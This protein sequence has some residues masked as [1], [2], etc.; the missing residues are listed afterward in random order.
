MA[1]PRHL[2]AVRLALAAFVVLWLLGPAVLRSLFPV[3]FVFLL[4]VGLELHFFLGA[5]RASHHLPDR[6][7]QE[8]DRERYGFGGGDGDDLL[9]VRDGDEDLWIRRPEEDDD[10]EELLAAARERPAGAPV[11][12]PPPRR[13]RSRLRGLLVAVMAVAAFGVGAWLWQS[14]T[15]W[16][17]LDA[18]ER[19]A[20][21]ARFS[22]EASVIAGKPVQ[23]RC[24]E[25]GEHVGAVQRADGV[26]VVGGTLAYL[27]PERCLDLYRLAFRGEDDGSQT[28]RSLA[29]LAHEAWHLRGVRD[30]GTTECY[31]LQ[32]AVA[33]GEQ[34]GLESGRA[35]Q[36]MRQQLT[37]NA[38][39]TRG[40]AQYLVPADCRD[41]GSLDLDAD[42]SRFP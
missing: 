37:E 19:A 31:A 6:R 20:A 28:A 22:E 42:G 41:G 2:V 3:W 9:L 4:A 39:R 10:L 26:A 24:D 36:L 33:L 12:R 14:Y 11:Q 34:L 13:R 1:T 5:R 29:V 32:S 15:G 25:G 21:V 8:A 30:E 40:S 18:D 23:I 7:P 17:G 38:L 16:S 27:T 35:R